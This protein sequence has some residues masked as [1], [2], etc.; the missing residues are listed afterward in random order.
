MRFEVLGPLRVHRD[1]DAVTVSGTLRRNLLAVLLARA[2]EPVAASTLLDTLWG[3]QDGQDA[4]GLRRLQ[5]QVHRLRGTLDDPE[6]LSFGPSGYCLRVRAGELDADQFGALL[7]EA[8][9]ADPRRCVELTREALDLWRGSPYQGFDVPD[10]L[11][12]IQRLSE[13]RLVAVEQLHAAELRL[14]RHAEVTGELTDLVRQHPLRER[15]H[16]L[17]MTALYLSG[18]QADALAAYRGARDVLAEDLGLDPGP[19]LRALEGQILRG[20]RIEVTAPAHAVPA[21]LPRDAA[22]FVGRTAE[23]ARLD[24]LLTEATAPVAAITGTGGAGKTALAVRWAHRNRDRFHDGQ[25]YVDLRGYGPDQPLSA[26]ETL[27]ALLRALGLDGAAIPQEPT[28]RAARFRTAVDRKNLLILLDNAHSTA[29]IRPLL[30]GTDTCFVLV[31]SRDSLSGLVAREGAHRVALGRMTA[32]EAHDLLGELLGERYHAEPE[33]AAELIERCVRLPLALRIAAERVRERAVA[34]LVTE[35]ADE[36]ARLDLLDS[37]DPDTSVRAVFATSYRRLEPEAAR[38]FR[39]F[40][41]HPGHDTDVHSLT[42]LTGG[43]SPRTTRRLLDTLVRAH[44]V[45]ETAGQRYVLHDL[46]AT[47]AAEL[48]ETVDTPAE[49]VGALTRLLDYYL[50]TASRAVRF[51]APDDLEINELNLPDSPVAA[52]PN[53]SD[54]GAALSWLDRERANLIRVAES[55]AARGLPAYTTSLSRVLSWYLDVAMYLDDAERLH[56]RA[57]DIARDHD[58][59]VAEGIA[60]RALGLVH[61]CAHRFADAE[62]SFEESLALHEKADARVFQATTLN[63]LGALC[64]F[65]GRVEDGIRHLRRSADLFHEFGH[66]LM[67]ERPLT[68]LAQLYLRQ[69]RPEDA[70]GCLRHAFT[71]AEEHD[72]PPGQFQTSYALAGVYRDTGRYSDALECAHRALHIARRSRFPNHETIALYRIGTIHTR[73]G[74]FT[75]ALRFHGQA[76]AI[77]RTSS[78]TQLEATV[79]NG[80]A[81]THAAAGASAEARRCHLDAMT[82]AA[83][84][85]ARYEHARA[86]AGLGDL[87]QRHGEHDKAVEHWQQALTTYRELRA[88]RAEEIAEKL[89]AVSG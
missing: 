88:P 45:D 50:H 9:A 24:R 35:L 7:D 56:T 23:L 65:A 28:E 6:R 42:A 20:E 87:H 78:S 54:Y 71:V 69:G 59:P 79:L 38:L 15:L 12:E 51:L 67:A 44:L 52:A 33:A 60:L 17:L 53:L 16:G 48:T 11:G 5:V 61:L 55:A 58:D 46:L 63:H 2:N 75:E 89:A 72:Y 84:R 80:T 18:R 34:E 43:D 77:A 47:Y 10:L 74:E 25:L 66:R 39:L 57:L 26:D 73:L 76:L 40:G 3:R 82:A 62:R 1:G 31:T 19:E 83:N 86:H 22:G 81:E 36:R 64:G 49:R 32:E 13:R 8:S 85:G 27:T 37:G 21:Q 29:Q 41:V 70:L 4:A 14:G 30:P 68:T